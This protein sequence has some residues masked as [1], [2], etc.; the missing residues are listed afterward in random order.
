[1]HR[2]DKRSFLA[3]TVF[4]VLFFLFICL[5]SN[6]QD[7]PIGLAAQ[8]KLI[9]ELGSQPAALNNASQFNALDVNLPFIAK[10]N[11]DPYGHK[12]S[13]IAENRR[14]IQRFLCLQK[15]ELLVRP[16]VLFRTCFRLRIADTKDFPGLS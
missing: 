9:S 5:F 15:N 14:I 7:Q 3:S 2:E 1:M 6:Q 13:M 12:F 10:T 8:F 11:F 4:G 16:L